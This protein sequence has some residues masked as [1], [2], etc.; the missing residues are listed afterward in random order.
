MHLLTLIEKRSEDRASSTLTCANLMFR[1]LL[2]GELS[3][4]DMRSSPQRTC[5]HPP[6]RALP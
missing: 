2:C 4:L 6:A 5:T 3:E 1:M